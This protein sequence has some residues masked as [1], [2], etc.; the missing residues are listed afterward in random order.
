MY[1]PEQYQRLLDL[2]P[3]HY[4]AAEFCQGTVAEMDAVDRQLWVPL[5][6]GLGITLDEE[7][8]RAHRAEGEPYCR[9]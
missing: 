2:V 1:R 5:G 8:L 4:N 6:P 9:D 3:S 7:Y